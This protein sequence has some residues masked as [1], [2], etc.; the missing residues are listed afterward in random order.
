M[1][2]KEQPVFNKEQLNKRQIGIVKSNTRLAEYR[3]IYGDA[4]IDAVLYGETAFY[5]WP[6]RAGKRAAL[7]YLATL[8]DTEL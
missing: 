3:K 1:S 5:S 6:R 2:N 4:L 7:G 8:L